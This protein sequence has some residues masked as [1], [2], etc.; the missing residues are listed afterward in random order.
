MNP[1]IGPSL[2]HS[3]ESREDFLQGIDFEIKQNEEQLIFNGQ[4]MG[5]A[6]PSIAPFALLLM[7]LL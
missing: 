3:K 7:P 4:E 6:T 5:L 2:T 1:F